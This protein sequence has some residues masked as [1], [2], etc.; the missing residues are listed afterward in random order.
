MKKGLFLF[1]SMLF[2]AAIAVS[3]GNKNTE[4]EVNA[5]DSTAVE[6]ATV[7]ETNV[8]AA[9]PAVNKEEILSKAREAGRAKCNCYQTDPASVE[10]CIKAILEQSYAAYKDDA[11]FQAEMKAEFDRCVKEKATEAGKKAADEGV[12]K[13]AGAISDRLNNKK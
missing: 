3:C 4:E 2:A 11:D 8:E 9:A 7:T 10:N 13:A 5:E 12:K 1:A 6:E